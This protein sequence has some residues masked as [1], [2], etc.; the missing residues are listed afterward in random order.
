MMTGI[1]VT[2][3]L[4]STRLKRKHLLEVDGHPIVYYLLKRILT[5]FQAERKNGHLKVIIATSD[6]AEN[7]SFERFNNEGVIVF[8]GSINNIP[9]RH[10]QAAQEHFLDAI[11]S[12]DG[13]DILCSVR[14]MRYVYNALEEGANYVKTSNLPFGMNSFGYTKKFLELSVSSQKSD[15]LETGW[16][17]IFDESQLVDIPMNFEIQNDLL[18]F[19]L[20]YDE[21]FLFFKAIIKKLGEKVYNISDEDL[22]KTVIS[23]HLYNTNAQI[24]KMYWDNFNATLEEEKQK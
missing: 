22:I 16:G 3:R 5:E 13:D 20:D 7:R 17:R 18:R 15:V 23:E 24:S 10:L 21:D 19:T 12:V 11:V 2:A 4:G 14:G 9:F 8:Y 6:E 1:L